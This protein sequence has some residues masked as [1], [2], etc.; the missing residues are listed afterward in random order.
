MMRMTSAAVITILIVSSRAVLAADG[1][2]TPAAPRIV[3]GDVV[4]SLP[5]NEAKDAARPRLTLPVPIAPPR[6]AIAPTRGLVLPILYTSYGA[7]QT[8]D[9]YTTIRGVR[10]GAREANPMMSG[11][12]GRPAAVWAIKG[13]ITAA[14]IA[15]A[16]SMWK[17]HRRRR[18]ITTMI[19]SNAL[20]TAVAAN[21]T[22]VSRR[23]R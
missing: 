20:M 14:S 17:Q 7:L 23:Q 19:I 2:V 11:L 9:A 4:A 1:S 21:N 18:A 5:A 22:A 16:E 13:G 15:L 8:Y 10:R 12:A 3:P 6:R